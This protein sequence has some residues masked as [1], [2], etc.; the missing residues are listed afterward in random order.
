MARFLG[1]FRG[2]LSTV[3]VD[4]IGI[5]YNFGLHLRGERF[6]VELINVSL[7]CESRPDWGENDPSRRFTNQRALFY[8]TVA[9]GFERD[10]IDGLT[11]EPT[12]GQLAG[13]RYEIDLH[14]RLKIE[15]KESARSRGVPSPD[16][17]DA[18]MLALG[19]PPWK[20]EIL[21]TRDLYRSEFN[22]SRTEQ[23]S[24]PFFGFDEIG[25]DHG[26][27]DKRVTMS[28]RSR[29]DIIAPGSLARR[30]RRKPGGAW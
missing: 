30:L 19:R 25:D 10:Q 17:A 5:G 29:W 27:D 15:S 2:R 23:R 6:P 21:T 28:P 8:Q 4:E 18:L 13:I 11:D 16:R 7:P 12:I 14:G 26:D 3:R 20:F 22:S 1:E 9:D 24:H